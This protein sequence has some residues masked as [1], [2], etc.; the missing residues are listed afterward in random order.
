MH[1]RRQL[2]VYALHVRHAEEPPA[3]GDAMAAEIH[4]RAAAGLL[5]VPEPVGVRTV[6]LLTLLHEMDATEGAL[7]RHLLRLHV[8][9]GEEKLLRVQQQ[10]IGLPARVDHLVGL[11]EG[12]AERLLADDVLPGAGGVDR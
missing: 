8:L 5:D 10:Y 11:L 9:W 2:R 12:D 6:V 4:E 3:K 1:L 7:V